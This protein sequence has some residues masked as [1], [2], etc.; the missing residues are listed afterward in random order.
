[1]SPF[2]QNSVTSLCAPPP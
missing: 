1:M 2:A